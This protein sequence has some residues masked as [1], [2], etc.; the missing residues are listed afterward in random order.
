MSALLFV[1]TSCFILSDLPPLETKSPSSI[2]HHCSQLP[3]RRRGGLR[4]SL[5]RSFL[6]LSRNLLGSYIDMKRSLSNATYYSI[7]QGPLQ[8]QKIT[9]H[10]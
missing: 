10:R 4:S 2:A 7:L 1:P 8:A 6:P 3:L 5:L 9:F